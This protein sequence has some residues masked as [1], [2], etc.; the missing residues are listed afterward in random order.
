M[1]GSVPGA[2]RVPGE[3]QAA[4]GDHAGYRA[5]IGGAQYWTPLPLM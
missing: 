4:L 2:A 1:D 5:R 3:L